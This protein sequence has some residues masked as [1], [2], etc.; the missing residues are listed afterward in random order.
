M[1]EARNRL[2]AAYMTS[3]F[4]GGALGSLVA[5]YAYKHSGWYGVTTAGMTICVINLIVW[6]F[7]KKHEPKTL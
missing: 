3:Y 2:T 6:F 5:G 7:G 4:I 1:P